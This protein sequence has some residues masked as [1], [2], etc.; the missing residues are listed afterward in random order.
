MK[1]QVITPSGL[2][3]FSSDRKS[4]CNAYIRQAVNKGSERDFLKVIDT[5]I[6]EALYS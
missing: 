4:V 3:V 5:K 1:Y 2:S 6:W